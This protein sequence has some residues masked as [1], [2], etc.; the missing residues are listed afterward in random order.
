M[1]RV[2]LFF[3][4]RPKVLNKF[5]CMAKT[6]VLLLGWVPPP[7]GLPNFKSRAGHWLPLLLMPLVGLSCLGPA[8]K[9][10]CGNSDG[11]KERTLKSGEWIGSRRGQ[12]T[13]K[14]IVETFELVLDGMNEFVF[15]C[16]LHPMVV[17]K[18]I[19]K[20]MRKSHW[21]WRLKLR[22]SWEA[23]QVVLLEIK[24]FLEQILKWKWLDFKAHLSWKRD[25]LER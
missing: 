25:R 13:V 18:F 19:L 24:S 12:S 9:L 2:D 23:I 7:M 17:W 20:R 6:H 1:C 8:Y 5:L 15:E 14:N 4:L 11:Q 21:D 3:S 16:Q 22:R 10:Y